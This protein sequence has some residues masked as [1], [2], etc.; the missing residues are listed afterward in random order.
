MLL[1]TQPIFQDYGTIA[2]SD[3]SISRIDQHTATT[4]RN[5]K[6]AQQ[7]AP[8]TLNVPPDW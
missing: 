1:S 8:S 2:N 4:F 5:L 7:T 6:P 3:V